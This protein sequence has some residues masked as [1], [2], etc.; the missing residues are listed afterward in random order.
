[1]EKRYKILSNNSLVFLDYP[2]SG[3]ELTQMQ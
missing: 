2:G 3:T 1:M